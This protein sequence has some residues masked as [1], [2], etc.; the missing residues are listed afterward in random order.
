VTRPLRVPP[1]RR[2]VP[3]PR[4][5]QPDSIRL[6]YLRA[7]RRMLAEAKL[8]VHLEVFPLLPEIALEAARRRGDH[9]DADPVAKLNRAVDKI[10]RQ[11]YK[12]YT[13]PKISALARD[14][15]EATSDF[16]RDQL[17]GQI[18][19]AIAV[20]PIITETGLKQQIAAFTAEN[21]ALIKSIPDRFFGE[22]EQRIISG[23]REGKRYEEIAQ[24]VQDRTGVAEDR[25]KLVARDQ[26][27]KFYGELQESR[28]TDLG[29]T[30]YIWRTVHD[31]RVRPEHAARDGMLCEWAQGPGDPT[32][33]GDGE[34]PSDGI[35]CRCYSEPVLDDLTG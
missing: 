23:V 13:G 8:L 21:V 10:S 20:D 19:S 22:V 28:Q 12:Q 14:A 2:L 34:H 7:L 35:N 31:E 3:L 11:F 17:T 24:E 18:R 1:G 4:Q 5:A 16:Q 15:A 26:V 29:I 27:G 33:P 9:L 25:A 32:D 30:R 6:A